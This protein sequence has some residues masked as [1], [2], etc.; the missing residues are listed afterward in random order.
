MKKSKLYLKLNYNYQN[1]DH[2]VATIIKQKSWIQD[3]KVVFR[4]SIIDYL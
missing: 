1:K 3:R 2:L 4:L